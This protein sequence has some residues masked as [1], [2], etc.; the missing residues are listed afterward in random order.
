MLQLLLQQMTAMVA[1]LMLTGSGP[2]E[3]SS[4]VTS[5]TSCA[6]QHRNTHADMPNYCQH[7]WQFCATGASLLHCSGLAHCTHNCT[8]LV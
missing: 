8:A 5:H 1:P 7:R 6:W 3:E 2:Q 4:F